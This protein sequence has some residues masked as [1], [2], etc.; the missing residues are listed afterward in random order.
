[1]K[2]INKHHKTRALCTELSDVVLLS[3][4][5]TRF[6]YNFI[7]VERILRCE[8]HVRKLMGSRVFQKR[9]KTQNADALAEAK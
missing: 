7:M 3:P 1:V 8:E 5:A 9:C 6:G 4:A 2:F